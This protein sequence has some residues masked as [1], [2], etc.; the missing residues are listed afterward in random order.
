MLCTIVLCYCAVV[1]LTVCCFVY[2]L[3]WLRAKFKNSIGF[4]FTTNLD[5]IIMFCFFKSAI[6]LGILCK[7]LSI[8]ERMPWEHTCSVS[9]CGT[10]IITPQEGPHRVSALHSWTFQLLEPS[11]K[12]K[13][14]WGCAQWC[15][16]W[17]ACMRLGFCQWC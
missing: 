17:L 9:P 3:G 16:P 13:K 6:S 11:N 1:V 7:F 5:C 12:F 8:K 4:C 15:S 10:S 14:S 2:F